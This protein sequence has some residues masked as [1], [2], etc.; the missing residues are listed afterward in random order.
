MK[1]PWS[2]IFGPSAEFLYDE[3]ANS[4]ISGIYMRTLFDGKYRVEPLWK[5]HRTSLGFI[6]LRTNVS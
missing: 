1:T 5:L 4:R 6:I 3:I 2:R